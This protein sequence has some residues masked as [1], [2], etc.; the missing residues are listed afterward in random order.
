VSHYGIQSIDGLGPVI[1][2]KGRAAPSVSG[3][4][5]GRVYFDSGSNQFKFSENGSAYAVLSAG[6][7]TGTF[8]N[9]NVGTITQGQVVYHTT[10]T[11]TV[12]LASA[13]RTPTQRSRSGS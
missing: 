8:T 10:A 3:S 7:T 4:G 1:R 6:G 9:A 13:A 2:F 12:D 11:A 5:E